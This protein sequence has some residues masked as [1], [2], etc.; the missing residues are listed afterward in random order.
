MTETTKEL[1]GT[2]SYIR[3]YVRR[4]SAE[5]RESTN[6]A[7]HYGD[8]MRALSHYHAFRSRE[9][10]FQA[11][12]EYDDFIETF[13]DEETFDGM[14]DVER[15]ELEDA[16]FDL[17]SEVHDRLYNSKQICFFEGV[18]RDSLNELFPDLTGSLDDIEVY[19]VI[20]EH[21]SNMASEVL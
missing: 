10:A 6:F 15:I 17:G 20:A 11:Q 21:V 9:F 3:D 13:N 18:D 5:A 8:R 12:L 4:S 1:H 7:R 2:F 16:F 14:K 19:D